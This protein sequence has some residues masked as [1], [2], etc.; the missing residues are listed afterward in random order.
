MKG[1]GE[2]VLEQLDKRIALMLP[3]LNERQR[4]LYNHFVFSKFH[5]AGAREAMTEAA[6]EA[7]A[8]DVWHGWQTSWYIFAAYACVVAVTFI[9]AF[10]YKPD[11]TPA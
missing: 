2:Q 8:M 4:R 6:K 9:F 7:L 5:A 10:K 11:E 3:L 1:I